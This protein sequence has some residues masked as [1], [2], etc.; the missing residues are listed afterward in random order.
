[1]KTSL[2]WTLLAACA[3]LFSG[4]TKTIEGIQKDSSSAWHGTKHV[5]HE[6]TAED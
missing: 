3:V 5:I 2:F 1:M 6:A 4:C